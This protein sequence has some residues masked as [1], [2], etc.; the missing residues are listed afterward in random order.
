MTIT[1][2][3]RRDIFDFLQVSE[4]PWC[5]RMEEIVFLSRLYDLGKL[6]STDNRFSDAAGDI[7]QHR[8][9]NWDWDEDWV[10][11]DSR[12]KLQNG[13]DE[14]FLKF[15]CETMHPIVVKS[16]DQASILLENYNKHL[17]PD[18]IVLVEGSEI[19]GRPIYVPSKNGVIN[20]GAK[21]VIQNYGSRGYV[22]QQLSRMENAIDSDPELAIG[23]SKELVEGVCKTILTNHHV[24]YG[25]ND[26]LPKIMK[27]TAKA[28]QL[29]RDDVPDQRPAADTIRRIL[30]NFASIVQSIAEL[31]NSYGTGHGKASHT[32]GLSP[33]HARLASGAAATVVTFLIETEEQ[34]KRSKPAPK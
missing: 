21:T 22:Q 15:L 9:N 18:G 8:V 6:P 17:A 24:P 27:L 34:R 4:I 16:S 7:H 33:R 25:K 26:D 12:F 1:Q 11:Y 19:S 5:G 28:L 29:S 20:V 13:S 14:I 32:V 3:T 23:T 31:R 10:F 2:L 30:S